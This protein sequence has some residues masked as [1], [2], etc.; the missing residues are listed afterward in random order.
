MTFDHPVPTG[1]W[2]AAITRLD[3]A[4]QLMAEMMVPQPG[5]DDISLAD[6]YDKQLA[7]II[8]TIDRDY[9]RVY[10]DL[11]TRSPKFMHPEEGLLP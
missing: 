4:R 6:I 9:K 11:A 1:P 2:M 3:E 8:G 10:I 7:V 5:M